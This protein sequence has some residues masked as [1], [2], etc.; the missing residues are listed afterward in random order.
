MFDIRLAALSG[1]NAGSIHFHLIH[2]QPCFI[3]NTGIVFRNGSKLTNLILI[4]LAVTDRCN[5]H[6]S[7]SIGAIRFKLICI[8]HFSE[9]CAIS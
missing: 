4:Y 7:I 8:S 9:C 6:D 1:L 3:T 2:K 5:S